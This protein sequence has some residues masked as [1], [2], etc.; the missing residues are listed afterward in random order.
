MTLPDY[1]FVKPANWTDDHFVRAVADIT[2]NQGATE[3][4]INAW[5]DF[6]AETGLRVGIAELVI[7]GEVNVDS[8]ENGE[9]TFCVVGVPE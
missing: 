4:T 8:N 5:L 2:K 7:N 9:L 1:A 6:I 3:A